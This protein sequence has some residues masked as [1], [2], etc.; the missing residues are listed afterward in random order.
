[1][2]MLE[3]P[4]RKWINSSKWFQDKE[5]SLLMNA[6]VRSGKSSSELKTSSR[7]IIL[8]KTNLDQLMK[9]LTLKNAL[10]KLKQWPSMTA[11]ERT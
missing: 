5:Q 4:M 9:M 11:K 8:M 10:M 2:N 1:M 3:E 6:N 7:F